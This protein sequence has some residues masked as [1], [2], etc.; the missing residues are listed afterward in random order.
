[1]VASSLYDFRLV[2]FPLVNGI[3]EGY[4]KTNLTQ[5]PMLKR[6]ANLK[7]VYALL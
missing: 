7:I 6:A 2:L 3:F 4:E 5:H 1:M